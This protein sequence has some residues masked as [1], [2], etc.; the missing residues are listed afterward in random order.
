M[1]SS[2]CNFA[3]FQK[4]ENVVKYIFG[5]F[6]NHAHIAHTNRFSFGMNKKINLSLW[7]VKN[8]WNSKWTY[9]E[10]KQHEIL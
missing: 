8:L 2:F 4:V 6:N 5:R 10:E 1:F 9:K 7:D 3:S